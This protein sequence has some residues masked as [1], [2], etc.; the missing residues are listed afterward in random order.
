MTTNG[1]VRCDCRGLRLARRAVGP[2]RLQHVEGG[3]LVQ[4]QTGNAMRPLDRD[5]QRDAAAIGV[6]DEMD[7]SRQASIR[8]TTA[9]PRRRDGTVVHRPSGL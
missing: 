9:R 1:R 8:P 4:R 6:A 7:A 5:S 2:T 3:R